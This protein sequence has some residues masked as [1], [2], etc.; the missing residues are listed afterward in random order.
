MVEQNTLEG[1]Y[2][3]LPQEPVL[4]GSGSLSGLADEVTRV[5][6]SRAMVI[7]GR[8]LATQTDVIA[9]VTRALARFHVGTYTGI[10]QHTPKSDVAQAV[11]Q[12]RTLRVDVLVSVGGGSPIDATKAVVMTLFQI[13]RA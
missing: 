13:G 11:E 5:G 9:S 7:T 12:A 6:G 4:F 8:S 3:F 1:E 2:F 10:R